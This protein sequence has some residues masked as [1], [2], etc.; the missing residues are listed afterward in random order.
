[1]AARDTSGFWVLL[2]KEDQNLAWGEG[3]CALAVGGKGETPEGWVE[4]AGSV[5]FRRW[6]SGDTLGEWKM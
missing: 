2:Y 5:L 3:V 1:M 4:H 6:P